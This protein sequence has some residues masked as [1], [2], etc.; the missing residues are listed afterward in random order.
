MDKEKYIKYW[1]EG[2]ESDLN[3]AEIL[4]NNKKYLHGLF[5]C[6]LTIEK[7]AKALW[8]KDK[9]A[10]PPKTHNIIYLV[11]NL[12]FLEITEEQMVFLSLLMKY[13]LEG[14]YPEYYPN[15]PIIDDVLNIFQKTKVL[16]QCLK[17]K[18]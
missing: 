6:H 14:R 1:I 7:A 5:F 12:Q 17:E 15:T 18:L 10:F 4:I 11:E 3:S 2:A 16:F 13:Q 9:S 8:V